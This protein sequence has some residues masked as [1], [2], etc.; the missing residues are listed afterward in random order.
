[1]TASFYDQL[2]A[3]TAESER[4]FRAIPLI[5]TAISV[6]VELPLYST[7]L[8]SAYHHVR[9]TCPLMGLALSRCSIDD[10]ALR[11]GLLRLY[12]RGEGS[13]GMDPR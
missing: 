7:F 13:R 5:A 2:R 6:G 9:H 1:M 12:R 10:G 11:Q 4:E 3:D 8:A